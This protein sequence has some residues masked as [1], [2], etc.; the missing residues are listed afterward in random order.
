MK[1]VNEFPA[2]LDPVGLIASPKLAGLPAV[3]AGKNFAAPSGQLYRAPE[4][5][6][7][8]LPRRVLFG[9]LVG[10][11]ENL[12][13]MAEPE[14]WDG[15]E[16]HIYDAP[17]PGWYLLARLERLRKQHPVWPA[18]VKFIP[19]TL[20]EH[21]DQLAAMDRPLILRDQITGRTWKMEAEPE[22]EAVE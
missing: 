21:A 4:S 15:V 13:E 10:A 22:L 9:V 20:I 18:H 6:R 3:W 11:V 7:A 19:Q 14:A 5:F 8:L 17:D 12:M 2:D 16:F 1:P